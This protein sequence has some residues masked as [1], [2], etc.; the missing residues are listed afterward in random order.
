MRNFDFIELKLLVFIGYSVL[1]IVIRFY[2][3]RAKV[4]KKYETLRD[5]LTKKAQ[6]IV[7]YV[8]F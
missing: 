6:R 8:F 4:R 3:S 5:M 7:Q 1:I 2:F